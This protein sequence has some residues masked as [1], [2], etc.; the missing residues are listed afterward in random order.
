MWFCFDSLFFSP[1]RTVIVRILRIRAWIA[2]SKVRWWWFSDESLRTV[3]KLLQFELNWILV[4]LGF[5]ECSSCSWLFLD[6]DLTA[7]REKVA[8]CLYDV[9]SDYWLILTLVM[10]WLVFIGQLVISDP[11]NIRHLCLDLRNSALLSF[12][13][14]D[15]FAIFENLGPIC[16]FEKKDWTA[17]F[18]TKGLNRKLKKNLK[19]WN[20][21]NGPKCKIKKTLGTKMQLLGIWGLKWKLKIK[22]N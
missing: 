10:S 13:F 5:D 4:K 12:C 1:P 7:K 20:K 9:A 11:M 15:L 18:W 6:F 21:R 3:K 17:N 19:D 14:G 8:T 16:K 22:L 2:V